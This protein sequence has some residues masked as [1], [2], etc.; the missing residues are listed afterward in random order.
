MA[1]GRL[2]ALPGTSVGG[3]TVVDFGW[4]TGGDSLVAEFVFPAKVQLASWHPGATRLAVADIGP[5]QD[6]DSVVVG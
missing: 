1:S 4:P 6:Q 5:G 3:D 2:T